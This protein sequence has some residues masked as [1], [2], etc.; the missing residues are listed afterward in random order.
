MRRYGLILRRDYPRY[1]IRASNRRTQRSVTSTRVMIE[2]F[3]V[4]ALKSRY[5]TMPRRCL[6]TALEITLWRWAMAIAICS[7]NR[8]TCLTTLRAAKRDL[9]FARAWLPNEKRSA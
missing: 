6:A 9:R 5:P 2:F 7:R 4:A 3:V 1:A 8:P